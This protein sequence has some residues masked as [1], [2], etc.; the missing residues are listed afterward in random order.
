MSQLKLGKFFGT[1]SASVD[2]DSESEHLLESDS[3]SEDEQSDSRKG[4]NLASHSELAC[5]VLCDCQ[6]CTLTDS[7]Y[8][9]L[10]VSNSKKSRVGKPKTKSYSRKIQPEWYKKYPWITVCT[11]TFKIFCV[12]CRNAKQKGL[13]T[14]PKNKRSA[15]IED[16]F[17]NWKK[18]TQRFREHEKSVMHH[19]ALMKLA[20][21]TSIS[22][23]L[24]SQHKQDQKFH[25]NMLFK[26][27]SC[28]RFLARQGLALRGHD[29]SLLSFGGN[30][31]QLLLLLAKWRPGFKKGNT[32]PL[33]L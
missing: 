14:F 21:N 9:P 5:E 18:A 25:L 26:L 30:L 27:L 17:S 7:V 31:Y 28:I 3:S 22:A 16:G 29:E 6:G 11:S 20:A 10:E 24:S 4:T 12:F 1:A 2:T 8:Q 32:F 15:F 13:L 19:E 33:K 23:Q